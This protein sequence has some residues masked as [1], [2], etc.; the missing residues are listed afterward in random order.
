VGERLVYLVFGVALSAA[1]TF[2]VGRSLVLERGP[3]II[4]ALCAFGLLFGLLLGWAI[5]GYIAYVRAST[6][7]F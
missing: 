1:L 7:R 5:D 4:P 2:A 6:Q 3:K